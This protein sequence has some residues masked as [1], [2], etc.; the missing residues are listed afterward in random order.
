MRLWSQP[1]FERSR[2]NAI[3]AYLLENTSLD[4]KF[5]EILLA[6][7]TLETDWQILA[8]VFTNC[9]A[10]HNKAEFN[11]EL[12]HYPEPKPLIVSQL[13]AARH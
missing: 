2:F 11:F 6:A 10:S 7:T 13:A 12:I 3:V 5:S 8:R 4:V 1:C 9:S